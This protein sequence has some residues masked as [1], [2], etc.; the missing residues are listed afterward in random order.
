LQFLSHVCYTVNGTKVNI[1]KESY[2]KGKYMNQKALKTL[3]YHKIIGTLIEYATS[4]AGK[5]LC[6]HLVPS[7]DYQ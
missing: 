4:D 1:W 7:T 5:E 6:K 3:E 2:E